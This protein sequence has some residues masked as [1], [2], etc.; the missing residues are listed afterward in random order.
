[1]HIVRKLGVRFLW[2]DPLYII[3]DGRLDWA[4]ECGR[5]EEVFALAYCTIAVSPAVDI[6]SEFSKQNTVQN[7]NRDHETYKWHKLDAGI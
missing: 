6:E 1:M 7:R 2:I 3:Q 5:M 4:F